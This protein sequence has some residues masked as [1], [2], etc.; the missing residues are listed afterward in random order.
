MP[1]R[2]VLIALCRPPAGMAHLNVQRFASS[3]LARRAANLNPSVL[4]SARGVPIA[5]GINLNAK[6]LA[7]GEDG[8]GHGHGPAMRKDFNM[9]KW[10]ARVE[11]GSTGVTRLVSPMNG[12]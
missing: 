8:H 9:P 4:S 5:N 2:A 1:C 11:T 7:H 10:A 12:E 3:Q 6:D